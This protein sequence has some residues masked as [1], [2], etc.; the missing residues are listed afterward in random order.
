[1]ERERIE[2]LAMDSALGELSEDAA[3]L[4]EA[5]LATNAPAREWARRMR[6]A[7]EAAHR[8]VSTKT[9][10]PAERIPSSPATPRLPW[11][12]ICPTLGRWAAV[13]LC[14]LL[15]GAAAGRWSKPRDVFPAGVPVTVVQGAPAARG[16]DRLVGETGQGFWRARALA[17]VR[18]ESSR[19]QPSTAGENL[20]DK[21]R[22]YVR[23]QSDG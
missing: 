15:M 20:W 16:W 2:R 13:I 6:C 9:R 7:C 3:A 23:E 5:Y 18:S 1:M 17:L 14:A 22:R 8:V 11:R 21:Y 4:L 12:M 19:A 10:T